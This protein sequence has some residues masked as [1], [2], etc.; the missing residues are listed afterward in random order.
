[1]TASS[2]TIALVGDRSPTVRAHGRIPLLID[3]LRRRDG[4]VLDPYWIPSTEAD[5]LEGFDG[6][7]IVPGSPYADREKVI[8]AAG[9]ARERGIPF[10]GT[11][12][13]FQHAILHL[14]RELANI[15]DADHSEYGDHDTDV[16]V[17]LECSLVGHE[18]VI[19]YT[20]GT[21]IAKIAGV[22]Q[23]LER[24]HCSYGIAPEFVDTLAAAGVVFGA[25]DE[26]G[27]PRALELPDH[28][29]FLGTLFQPEL[30]G[31]GSRAHPVIRA[32]AEAVVSRATAA[33]PA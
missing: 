9:V 25:H 23:R 10:L 32:Y 20:P 26:D 5:D 3:A 33:Q 7:W 16:I 22:D 19:R 4:L 27:A 8:A 15:A 24:Y 29:F 18:G 1:M 30:A 31:D 6:I 28:P 12:G 21:L 17:P 2:A 13:G 11:C 14:A